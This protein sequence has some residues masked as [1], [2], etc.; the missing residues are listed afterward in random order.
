MP[1]SSSRQDKK[2]N[3]FSV[4]LAVSGSYV[5]E[6]SL[7]FV[8]Q[9]LYA[10]WQMTPQVFNKASLCQRQS[11]QSRA[12]YLLQ[13]LKS[14]DVTCIWFLRGG[15]GSA[16]IIPYLR[17]YLSDL[18][19]VKPKRVLGLSDCTAPLL[20]LAQELGWPVAYGMGALGFCRMAVDQ[21]VSRQQLI[22]YLRYGQSSTLNDL[23][24]LNMLAKRG[25]VLQAELCIGNLTLLTLSIKDCWEFEAAGKILVIEDWHEAVYAIDRSLKY[26]QRIGKLEQL[27]GLI[28]GDFSADRQQRDE[29]VCS[30]QRR[31]QHFAHTLPVPVWQTEWVGHGERQSAL[32]FN[33]MMRLEAHLQAATLTV[34][35]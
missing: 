26:L 21:E 27:A 7:D 13:L 3:P 9:S 5:D 11:A 14:P 18:R 22:N 2:P 15:E 20:F 4:A 25:P 6:A 10:D 33:Q 28:L 32:V 16:D 8:C 24:P 12:D 29:F 34:M 19:N 35:D 17:P 23:L 31:L 30:L 1:A